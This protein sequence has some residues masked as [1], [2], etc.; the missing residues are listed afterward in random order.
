M[1]VLAV[2]I[3]LLFLMSP[4]IAFIA[5][6]K[7]SGLQ[8]DIDGL[9]RD[10]RALREGKDF[11]EV[12]VP[13]VKETVTPSAPM[14]E[15]Q[16]AAALQQPTATVTA[17]RP[18]AD[19]P[20]KMKT[21]AEI[22][23]E[24]A[25]VASKVQLSNK[26]TPNKTVPKK[27]TPIT[28][29]KPVKPKATLEEMIGSQWSV[30]IGGIAL[31]I[32]AIFLIRFSIEAGVFSPAMRLGLAAILGGGALAAGEWMRRSDG[33]ND[34]IASK[35]K[36]D[37]ENSRGLQQAYIPGVLTAVGIFTWLGA[38]YAGH[39]LYE[40]YGAGIAFILLG[41]TSLLGLALGLLHGPKLAA[42]GLL[43]AF[44]T[45]LLVDASQP[46]YFALYGYLLLIAG[47]ALTLAHKRNWYEISAMALFGLLGWSFL[48]MGALDNKAMALLWT[49]FSAFAY[50]IATWAAQ[51]I[52]RT[53]AA[54]ALS[55][56]KTQP[57]I[58]IR[59][60]TLMLTVWAMILCAIILIYFLMRIGSDQEK[61][62][63]PFLFIALLFVINGGRWRNVNVHILL[64][65]V[66]ALLTLLMTTLSMG[67]TLS[68]M[69]VT[70]LSIWALCFR[71][72]RVVKPA[73]S[74]LALEPDVW[75]GISV[76]LPLLSWVLVLLKTGT[77]LPGSR[78]LNLSDIGPME[79]LIY[80]GLAVLFAGTAEYL[81]RKT[82]RTA[83]PINIYAIGSGA[84]ILCAILF[85]LD[86]DVK[87]YACLL[88]AALGIGLYF[89]RP[90][91]S[92]RIMIVG[93]LGLSLMFVIY[94][95]I[96]SEHVGTTYV[97]NALWI[98]L[99]LPAALCFAGAWALKRRQSDIW[100]EGLKAAGLASAAL[101][102]V[103][104][105]HHM[106][107][108]GQVLAAKFSLEET[109]LIVL[110]GFCFTFGASWLERGVSTPLKDRALH[111][112]LMPVLSIGF[113]AVTLVI[114]V[115][116][117]CLGMNPLLNEDYHVK[118][119]FVLNTLLLAYLLP[120]LLC[121]AIAFW[122]KGSRP[123]GYVK[124]MAGLG[125]I[126]FMIYITATV[127]SLFKG[128]QISIFDHPPVG[129]ELYAISAVWLVIGIGLLVMGLKRE[130]RDIR[131]VSGLVIILTVLKAFLI[132]MNNLEGVLRAMS[133]V[134][135]GLVLIVIG[136]VYQRLI[137][138]DK[139]ENKT[140]G[141]MS[142]A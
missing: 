34:L 86:V 16:K 84:A 134:I 53:A 55:P 24:R 13:R 75:A 78:W 64:G 36:M 116:A 127:R 90:L 105:I 61:M 110:T 31:A 136:R 83:A 106:M 100:S 141:D 74:S 26:T 138:S 45:P 38:I 40:F 28:P 93:A 37:A 131:L 70:S 123:Q 124:A 133:F 15:P 98:F 117:V 94:Y 9:R 20:P 135:L 89:I 113:S 7:S 79:G 44:A 29:S 115:L 142:A 96:P 39:A 69:A 68:L 30:W 128:A 4:I 67:L 108:G 23:K 119:I 60:D 47:A 92:L 66:L 54:K 132:D 17:P 32:G 35:L 19:A 129:M 72:S 71:E 41:L 85:C 130:N 125:F 97:F 81:W 76:G 63:W 8:R 95:H 120:S 22:R 1:E 5:L 107:N 52:E 46:N 99:A 25:A 56:S 2:I 103:M 114:F 82:E 59:F 43:A 48:S 88:A 80:I 49:G 139:S 73:S 6:A 87:F 140:D 10:I 111:E 122:T 14:A 27:S 102:I 126:S 65:G 11:G 33:L 58:N 118:G 112:M 77:S 109:A 121:G 3:G 42:L 101:F 104:Q 91:S 51:H 21:T 12:Q 57:S 137:F 18:S 50:G 62:V